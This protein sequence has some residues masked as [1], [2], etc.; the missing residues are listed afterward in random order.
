MIDLRRYALGAVAMVAVLAGC[1]GNANNGVVP[2][3]STPNSLPHDKTFHHTGRAQDFKV[4]A[5][6][7]QITVLA[8]GAHGAGSPAAYGGRV[9]AV[10]P[11]TPGETLLV[12]V[13]GDASGT[14]GGFNGGGNGGDEGSYAGTGGGGASDVREGGREL[15]DRV[16]VAGGGGAGRQFPLH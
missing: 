2:A 3:S 11:V 13:G 10:I 8:L 12:F 14:G 6:V 9:H 5:G 7:T 4:P 15:S 16:L 1:G